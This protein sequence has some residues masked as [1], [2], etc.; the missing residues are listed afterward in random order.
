MKKTVFLSIFLLTSFFLNA[1]GWELT[2]GGSKYDMGHS[3]KQTADGGYIV[4][5]YSENEVQ[6]KTQF[7]LKIDASGNQEWSH[8]TFDNAYSE[9]FSDVVQTLDGGYAVLCS[10]FDTEEE[11]M[12]VLLMKTNDFGEEEWRQVYLLGGNSSATSLAQT[13]DA[14]FILSGITNQDAAIIKTNALGEEEWVQSFGGAAI[15]RAYSVKQ[16][17]D[18]GY[19]FVGETRSFGNGEFDTWL[20]KLNASGEE[21][22][23]QTY[24]TEAPEG[25]YEVLQTADG[26]FVI[27]VSQ[28]NF[29]NYDAAVILLKTNADGVEEWQELLLENGI[30]DSHPFVIQEADGGYAVACTYPSDVEEYMNHPCL[31]KTTEE[32]VVDWQVVFEVDL[33]GGATCVQQTTD[34]GFVLLGGVFSAVENLDVW[35]AKTNAE[36]EIAS[37]FTIPSLSSNN[38]AKIVDVLGREVNL[39]LNTPLFYI[40]DDGRVEKRILLE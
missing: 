23:S 8:Q 12:G 39:Q 28:D 40:Y 38:L 1:Q 25:G 18:G 11:D 4:T 3:I 37:V 7:L 14:G 24:G 6:D 22:W 29:L 9:E 20:V 17:T 21:E 13:A 31:I 36:G 35:V 32:G 34:G 19:V 5:G 2:Y 10:F 16:T 15:D 27:S 26:G 33:S 30:N